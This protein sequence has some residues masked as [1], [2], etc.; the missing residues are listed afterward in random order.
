M[1]IGVSSLAACAG[2][3][4]SARGAGGAR[5]GFA[6]GMKASATEPRNTARFMDVLPDVGL[7]GSAK[8]IRATRVTQ[9]RTVADFDRRYHECV[10]RLSRGVRR[11]RGADNRAGA[12]RRARGA[13]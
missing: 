8:L 3:V 7:L 13:G 1:T 4:G 2:G 10:S 9:G 12:A 6:P 5:V 11:R